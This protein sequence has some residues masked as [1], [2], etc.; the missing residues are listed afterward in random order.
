[1][2]RWDSQSLDWLAS[3]KTDFRKS[4]GTITRWFGEIVGYFEQGTT[5]GVVE[6]LIIN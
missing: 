1:L 4:I 5:N 3:A 6:E 2:G